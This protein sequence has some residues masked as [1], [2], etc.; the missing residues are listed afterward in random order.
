M[1]KMNRILYPT[2]FSEYSAHAI[3]YVKEF[4]KRFNA[5]VTLAH[6]VAVPAYAGS[7]EVAIDFASLQDAMTQASKKK[8]DAMKADFVKDGVETDC[9]IEIGTA[10][11]EIINIARSQEADLII[12]ATH[13]FGA[14]KH[15]LMGS[16]AERV[17]RKAPCP[18]LTLRHP[19]HE[20]ILP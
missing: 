20:F 8:I 11:V 3:P 4:A 13:G 12:L 15:I 18:V 17:V 6:V 19:E 9:V 10:F 16:T 14:L 5:K 2:D 7:Y 1:I